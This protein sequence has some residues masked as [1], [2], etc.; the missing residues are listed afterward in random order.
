MQELVVFRALEDDAIAAGLLG[1]VQ[2]FVRQLD[3]A[4]R[5]T[6]DGRCGYS[7]P[8]AHGE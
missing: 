3:C 5:G 8:D 7:Y 6:T 1:L 4:L 2:G